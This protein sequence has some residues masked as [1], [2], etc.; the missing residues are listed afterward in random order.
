MNFSIAIIQ[1][2]FKLDDVFYNLK[3]IQKSILDSKAN[4]I[5]FS[6]LSLNGSAS[7]DSIKKKSEEEKTKKAVNILKKTA[8]KKLIILGCVLYKKE[9]KYNSIALIYN[10]KINFCNKKKLENQYVDEENY[11]TKGKG[12]LIK[13]FFS[14]KI[15]FLQANDIYQKNLANNLEQQN[16]SFI[17]VLANNVFSYEALN[18]HLN[19]LKNSFKNKKIIYIN[20]LG[21]VNGYLF[22]GQSFAINN[23]KI[24]FLAPAF[25]AKNFLLEFKNNSLIQNQIKLYSKYEIILEALV[26]AIKTYLKNSGF[27]K[28]IL[29]LSGGVD[30]ALVLALITKAIG[31]ENIT[32]VMMPFKFTSKASLTDAK[33]CAK[34]NNVEYKS[35]DITTMYD[36]FIKTFSFMKFKEDSLSLQNIQARIRANILMALANEKNALVVATSNKT[37]S[38][39]G[40]ST[41]YGDMIGAISPISDL[42]KY[43]V[44]EL[45]AYINSISKK[46][47]KNILTKAPSAELAPNQTDEKNLLSYEKLDKIIELYLGQ[48]QDPNEIEKQGFT[49]S[50]INK[51]TSLIDKSEF[52][53]SQAPVGI[54]ITNYD[55]SKDRK[56]NI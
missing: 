9:K 8:P 20:A 43:E 22:S 32:A 40:Y 18:K 15:T 46:I 49:K 38:A 17:I 24:S 6:S 28:I 56:A 14:Q 45:C 53:R 13:D 31:K 34:L 4:I 21:F 51:I 23:E 41:I 5:C 54:K 30:S 42:L 39:L 36:A 35:I 48:N 1:D 55:L 27:K 44:Y 37:E 50:E 29:G 12:L 16:S 47:P 26:F 3:K 19:Y 11:F 33:E 52:K 2:L 7:L 10:N 25:F